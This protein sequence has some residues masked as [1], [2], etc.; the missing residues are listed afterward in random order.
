M[1]VKDR[2]AYARIGT[3]G[4]VELFK[5]IRTQIMPRELPNDGQGAA[6]VSVCPTVFLSCF[7][8]CFFPYFTFGMSTLCHGILSVCELFYISEGLTVKRFLEF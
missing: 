4:G 3:V 8:L 2:T 1:P 6:G 5:H 7:G